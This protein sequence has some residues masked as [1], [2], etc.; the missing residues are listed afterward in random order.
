MLADDDL[1][2]NLAM[3]GMIESLGKYQVFSFYNGGEV[4][5]ILLN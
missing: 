3:R 1:L 2:S 4:L 5:I